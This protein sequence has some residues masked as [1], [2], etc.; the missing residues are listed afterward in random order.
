MPI[1]IA[2]R[3]DDTKAR[4]FFGRLPRN[5]KTAI[6]TTI[7]K[8]AFIIERQSKRVTPVDTGRLRSSISSDITPF[9]AT[10]APHTNYAVFVHEGTRFMTA[11]P[12]M[13]KGAENSVSEVENILKLEL[14]KAV[15]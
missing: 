2:I 8:S 10:V 3:V 6:T 5:V 11:R 14:R 7:R 4:N 1:G 12:F 13:H 15:K 9:S